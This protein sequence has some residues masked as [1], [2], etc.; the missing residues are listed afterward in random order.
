MTFS[1]SDGSDSSFACAMS[2][3]SLETWVMSVDHVLSLPRLVLLSHSSQ[4]SSKICLKDA[5]TQRLYGPMVGG[6]R[7]VKINKVLSP[8]GGKSTKV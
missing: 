8:T 2:V 7:K 5:W 1:K 3:I 6:G 4:A